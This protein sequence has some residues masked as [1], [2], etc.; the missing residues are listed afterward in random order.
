MKKRSNNIVCSFIILVL[1]SS[2]VLFFFYPSDSELGTG[3]TVEFIFLLARSFGLWAG[4]II[5]TIRLLKIVKDSN[6]L[7]YIFTGSLNIS[8]GIIS[9]VLFTFK[10]MIAP[11]LHL[12]LL[13]FFI[14]VIIYID[15][16]LSKII[17]N[18]SYEE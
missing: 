4:I 12:F 16:F 13:N 10:E 8:L 2:F 11:I 6:D 3:F 1:W 7:A 17:F 14:G 9:I 5:L 15:V 18:N